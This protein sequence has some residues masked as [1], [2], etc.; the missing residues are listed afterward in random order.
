[1]TSDNVKVTPFEKCCRTC[2]KE[3]SL[4]FDLFIERLDSSSIADML[5]SC[6]TLK[7]QKDDTLPKQI[8]R[9]CYN[10]LVSFSHFCNM[11]QKAEKKLVE[12][13]MNSD[14]YHHI[15]FE[16]DTYEIKIENINDNMFETSEVENSEFVDDNKKLQTHNANVPHSICNGNEGVRENKYNCIHCDKCYSNWSKLK[17]H[18]AKHNSKTDSKLKH[19]TDTKSNANEH[20]TQNGGNPDLNV[21]IE[22]NNTDLM[23]IICASSFDSMQL[24]SV[25]MKSHEKNDWLIT[26]DQCNKVFKKVS[27][28]KRHKIVHKNVYPHDMNTTPKENVCTNICETN[29]EQFQCSKC[30]QMFKNVNSLSA[31]MRKHTEKGR[32]L[33]CKECN[34]VFK[35]ISHLKRHESQHEINRPYKCTACPKSFPSEDTLK[36]HVNTHRGVKPHVCPVCDKRFSHVSS[37]TTHIK[38]HTRDKSFLCPT[39]GK[40]FDSSTNLNQHISRHIGLKEYACAMCPKKFVS[41]G[42]LKSHASTHTGERSFTCDHCGASFTKRSSLNKHKIRHL[43]LKPHQCDTCLMRFTCKDHL[44][45][46]Y[47][48]HTGE[49]PY[50]CEMCGRAFTQ[51]NDLV[52]HRRAHLGDKVYKCPQ[53]TDSFRLNAELQRHISEHFISSRNVQA[54]NAPKH[55]LTDGV[56]DQPID[57]VRNQLADGVRDQLTDGVSDQLI[58]GVRDQLI[59]GVR[60]QLIVGGVLLTDGVINKSLILPVLK[61]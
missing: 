27:H 33:S 59:D 43:G 13:S 36:E 39:C 42:E 50:R 61:V 54:V 11:A 32:V 1:M 37:L 3:D 6:T 28:L 46:H 7:I 29:A 21:K 34:K 41:K 55:T 38:I 17:H 51:S 58:D 23:C 31:H 2:L 15:N 14:G 47:R 60:D 40:K 25:H 18:E 30:L 49:K 16:G 9:Y 20:L 44:K 8:C 22:T 19:S 4:M 56:S 53:C 5:L 35:K 10:C 57:G 48:I 24:L 45:R 52:K 12:A 26:C